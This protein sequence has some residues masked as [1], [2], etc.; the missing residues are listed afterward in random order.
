MDA[1]VLFDLLPEQFLARRP[2]LGI[3]SVLL[4]CALL[5]EPCCKCTDC[6]RPFGFVIRLA[7]WIRW[8]LG[9]WCS[10]KVVL[11]SSVHSPLMPRYTSHTWVVLCCSGVLNRAISAPTRHMVKT[12]EVSIPHT[13]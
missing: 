10:H 8:R 7:A 13:L 6:S 9:W 3:V 4:L 5:T 1:D 2:A 12:Y 11:S